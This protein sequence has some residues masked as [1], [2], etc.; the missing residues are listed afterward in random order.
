MYV[1][2]YDYVCIF[3]CMHVLSQS[4]VLSRGVFPQN[5]LPSPLTLVTP[6]ISTVAQHGYVCEICIYSFSND[7]G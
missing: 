2:M 5:S 7:S 1:C 3:V 4:S 6:T